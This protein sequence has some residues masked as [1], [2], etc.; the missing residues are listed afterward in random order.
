MKI[1][2]LWKEVL[3]IWWLLGWKLFVEPAQSPHL[4]WWRYSGP[5][6]WCNL[7]REKPLIT[8]MAPVVASA[9]LCYTD[10]ILVERCLLCK[11][12]CNLRKSPR[13]V[14]AWL[15]LLLYTLNDSVNS[16]RPRYYKLHKFLS[17]I[18]KV[19]RLICTIVSL[20]REYHNLRSDQMTSP[21]SISSLV[22]WIIWSISTDDNQ[23]TDKSPCS[24]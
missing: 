17:G 21:I 16:R 1:C 23:N 9:V 20:S 22:F 2:H 13:P 12:H 24:K 11:V 10:L 5:S 19:K 7:S 6:S 14:V 18:V 8:P 3:S 15:I 4:L